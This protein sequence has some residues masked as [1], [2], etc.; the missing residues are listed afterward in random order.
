MFVLPG[1]PAALSSATMLRKRAAVAGFYRF[2]S[3]RDQAV[4]PLLGE[5]VGPRPTGSFVPMLV[6]TRRGAGRGRDAE[7]GVQPAAVARRPQDPAD[8]DR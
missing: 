2:H 6:H 4:A 3:R 1:A 7:T 5:L 8:P